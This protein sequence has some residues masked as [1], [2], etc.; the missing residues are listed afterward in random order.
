MRSAHWQAAA[1]CVLV[2]AALWMVAGVARA[3]VVD[4]QWQDEGRFERGLAIAPGKF[5]EICGP[6]EAGQSVQWSF[7][8]D[9]ALDFNIRFHVGKD[10]RYP[11][12]K[13]QVARLQAIWW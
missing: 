6:L 13:D 10:V 4:L 3:E 12:Q 5:A 8:A 11:A 2:G 1:T 7:K 9:R